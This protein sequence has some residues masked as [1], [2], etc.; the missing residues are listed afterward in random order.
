VFEETLDNFGYS[1]QFTPEKSSRTKGNIL[2][3][4]K[5]NNVTV[6]EVRIS[7]VAK[8]IVHSVCYESSADNICPE[9]KLYV[10]KPLLLQRAS[11]EKL[12]SVSFD[13]HKSRTAGD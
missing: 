11:F 3:S 6:I 4:F 7:L 10:I 12:D 8:S 13:L 5:F 2:N 1:T 9:S